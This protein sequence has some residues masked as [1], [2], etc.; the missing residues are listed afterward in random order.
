[1]P[2]RSRGRSRRYSDED[3]TSGRGLTDRARTTGDSG[4]ILQGIVDLAELDAAPADLDLVVGAA[5]EEESRAVEYDEV[6]AAVSAV[7][8]EGRH[9]RVFLG[10]LRRVQV[11]GK[12]DT[13]DHELTGLSFGNGVALGIDDREIP[14][15]E[16]Q[17]DTD[18]TGA[19]MMAAHATTVASVG[20]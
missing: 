5:L 12:P 8:A 2:R 10:V 6:A 14:A 11:A 3:R 7:P 17:T 20:P 19:S 16:W 4:Q 1:M 15:V 18:R 9:G 13:A